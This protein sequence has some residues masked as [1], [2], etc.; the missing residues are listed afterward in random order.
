[1]NLFTSWLLA[2]T[3]GEAIG[4]FAESLG[5]PVPQ[6]PSRLSVEGQFEWREP[7]GAF[8]LQSAWSSRRDPVRAEREWSTVQDPYALLGSSPKRFV[9]SVAFSDETETLWEFSRRAGFSR[10]AVIELPLQ[11]DDGESLVGVASATSTI[12]A[13]IVSN[14]QRQI[15]SERAELATFSLSNLLTAALEGRA[16]MTPR[17]VR[18]ITDGG[19]VLIQER[20]V[21]RLRH[22]ISTTGGELGGLTLAAN[23][24]RVTVL[25]DGEVIFSDSATLAVV[26]SLLLTIYAVT[27][28]VSTYA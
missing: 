26:I 16:E 3:S 23:D 28:Q 13:S 14:L 10:I 24:E 18:L 11:G 2:Q 6:P 7:D 12:T 25:A 21:N 15:G 19:T 1:V 5:E 9:R 22:S 27:T 8:G 17:S 20:D 4:E